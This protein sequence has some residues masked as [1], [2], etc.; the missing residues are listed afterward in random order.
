M[1][2]NEIRD[3][4]S[5]IGQPPR[6]PLQTHG[7]NESDCEVL[8]LGNGTYL[9]ATID[10]VSEEIDVGLYREPY[11]IGWVAAMA[12]L[13]DLAAV[14][15]KPLGM[16]LSA[17]W[18]TNQDLQAKA[19]I[20]RGFSDALKRLGTY[21]LGGDSGSCRTTVLG[22]VGLGI[23]D[24]KPLSRMGMKPGDWLCVTGQ[25]GAGPALAI[26]F[27]MGEA[28]ECFPESHYLPVAQ[29]EAG[30][31][32]R[33]LA[34][35][36]MDTSDGLLQTLQTLRLLN[37]SGMELIW[38]DGLIS[39]PARTYCQERQIP[40]WTLW[41][42]EH[43]DYQLVLSIPPENL[44]KAMSSVPDLICIGQ[45]SATPGV[46]IQLPDQRIESIDPDL[47]Q[48]LLNASHQ[49]R[50]QALFKL[51]DQARKTQLP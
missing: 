5:W 33:G 23:C 8:N 11:R 19:E 9:A 17:E 43:G 31:K 13:S 3:L 16:L 21:W 7:L 47:A 48:S 46:R 50:R 41:E 2:V 26:R 27:L 32:L 1:S 39:A 14:G 51:I 15:A 36:A 22:G 4:L 40:L 24:S 34:S 20:A 44:E 25:L 35:A 38:K 42:V 12:S 10:T 29:I 18:G 28:P 49:N 45:V 6:S 30:M 37:G